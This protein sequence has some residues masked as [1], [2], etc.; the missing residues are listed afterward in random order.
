MGSIGLADLGDE[1]TAIVAEYFGEVERAAEEDVRAAA[2][3]ALEAVES[4]SPRRTG[5]YGRG[6]VSEPDSEDMA[7]KAYRVHN[8]AKPGLTHL[9]EKGHGGPHPAPAY[10]HIAPAAQAGFDELE[11]R[12]HG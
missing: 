4:G 8:R 11:R 6:W 7:A 9:L 3:A 2:D 5:R 10:P 1:I 12:M